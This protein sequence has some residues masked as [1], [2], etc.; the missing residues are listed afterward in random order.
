MHLDLSD[1]KNHETSLFT[2]SFLALVPE[3][4]DNY[5]LEIFT[6]SMSEARNLFKGWCIG[7]RP[8]FPLTELNKVPTESLPS[9]DTFLTTIS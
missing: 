9:P 6:V 4:I 1:L 2:S 3:P 8:D 7:S 5:D